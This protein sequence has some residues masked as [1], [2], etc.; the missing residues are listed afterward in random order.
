MWSR[1]PLLLAAA[2]FLIMNALLWRSEFGSRHQSASSVP[3]EI[4]WEKMLSAP[5]N[6]SLEIRH[7]GKRIGRGTWA[8][9]VGEPLGA[10]KRLFEDLAPEEGMIAEPSGY[11]IDFGGNFSIDESTRLRFGFDLRL[12]TNHQWQEMS[13]RLM[14]R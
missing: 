10:A 1:V 11:T 7:H 9:V 2:F 3:V 5:D 12:T 13:L 4:V 14:I 8:P 6:S